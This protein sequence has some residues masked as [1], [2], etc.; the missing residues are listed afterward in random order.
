MCT[1]P[2]HVK[3]HSMDYKPISA[4]GAV[5][6]QKT[7]A[8]VGRDGSVDWCCFPHVENASVFARILDAERGGHFTVQPAGSFSS[9]QRYVPRT[10]VLETRFQTATGQATLTDFMP[11]PDAI[12]DEGVP[13]GT[14]LRKVTC[15]HGRLDLK[16]EFE[17]RFDYARTVPTVETTDHGVV[18]TGN[19][20]SLSLSTPLPL[21]VDGASAEALTMLEEGETRWL[22]A[23]Y[24]H[25][26]EI[27]PD[28]HQTLLERVVDRWQDWV[29]IGLDRRNDPV[30]GYWQDVVVRSALTLKLLIHDDTGTI[31]AA[32][33]TSL[34]EDIGGVRN[35]DYRF[36]WIRDSAFTVRALSEL[37]HVDEAKEYFDT[38]LRH[39][40]DNDP[41]DVQPVFGLH[42]DTDLE[43][44]T[45]E[46]LSGYQGSR[47]V[48][49]GNSA[50][51]QTQLDVY[52]ELIHGVYATAQY[53]AEITDENWAV[54]KD[55]LD[56]VCG[57]WS[58]PD[59]GIWEMRDDPQQFVYSNVMCWV[60]L[61][62]G[63][64]IVEETE[65]DGD[66][67]CWR[68]ARRAIKEDVLKYGY[69]EDV[70]SF[71]QAYDN[72][73]L[74]ATS[75]LIPIL[76]FLPADD[77]RVQSTIDA[78]LD[79]ITT[80][81]L[82]ARYEGNDGLPGEEGAFVMCSFWLVTALSLSGRI[83]EARETFRQVMRYAS[84]QGL[85]A[86]EVDPATGELLGNYPQAF[87]HIGLINAALHLQEAE[88]DADDP[89]A[90]ATTGAKQSSGVNTST[91]AERE[92]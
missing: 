32:P 91:R 28:A 21:R 25:E 78:T 37:G 80:N 55:L 18:T 65:F 89:S 49:V 15:T 44:E 14:L 2:T 17:P 52:G 50:A 43:E 67:E 74:D 29:D 33:T 1:I 54:M 86:E 72:R 62:R 64:A 38:C 70:G 77:E 82:V 76:G 88:T 11:V 66:V 60:A 69:D 45:L 84:P 92:R 7:V 36:N 5:G 42:G 79:R 87:S 39:C 12:R 81:G 22:V 24:G 56:Y 9:T 71:V 20:E 34:P 83:T 30:G 51:D 47:P 46:H 59:V 40:A 4:Y 75:L 73:I 53:G 61:D 35:W 27:R 16:V 48:R 90:S 41:A 23:G 10:N 68:E 6:N 13:N 19:N 63:I 57:A 85:L 58:E 3:L 8:L 26:P 31:C